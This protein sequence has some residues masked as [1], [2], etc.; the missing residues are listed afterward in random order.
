MF[1]PSSDYSDDTLHNGFDE[2][3]IEAIAKL[4]QDNNVTADER[5]AVD[6]NVQE[7]LTLSTKEE[8]D[9]LMELESDIS[10]IEPAISTSV[11]GDIPEIKRKLQ[12]KFEEI[13]QNQ[14]ETP[15]TNVIRF[16]VTVENLIKL[17]GSMCTYNTDSSICGKTLEFEWDTQESVLLLQWKC[18]YNHFGHWDLDE[19]LCSRGSNKLYSLNLMLAAS[20]L[21]SGNKYAK[22]KLFADMLGMN[23][24]SRTLFSQTQRLYCAPAIEDYWEKMRQKI[25]EVLKDYSE[26]CL[27]GDG[28]NDST[29]HSAK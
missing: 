23:F 10:R 22:I 2:D 14:E 29:G 24:I 20:V 27:C 1:C 13:Y 25:L 6:F 19:I 18:L 15:E 7:K 4:L 12:E 26:L 8:S 21:F 3:Q 16:L 9:S 11:E 17:K 5:F 28:C